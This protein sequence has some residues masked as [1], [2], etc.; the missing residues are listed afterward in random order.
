MAKARLVY[1]E[2]FQS[3][4]LIDLPAV[5]RLL[6]IGLLVHCTDDALIRHSPSMLRALL[7]PG[8]RISVTRLQHFLDTFV[9]RSMLVRCKNGNL[10]AYRITNFS[11]YQHLR[12]RKDA[13][14]DE[15][16][17]ELEGEGEWEFLARTEQR[18]IEVEG[19]G[20]TN[21]AAG[22][23]QVGQENHG[24]PGAGLASPASTVPPPD[25]YIGTT[26][27]SALNGE[28][29]RALPGGGENSPLFDLIRARE[30]LLRV[31]LCATEAH[32]C[33]AG[34]SGLADAAQRHPMTLKDIEAWKALVE[35]LQ[36]KGKLDD[37]RSY[38]R[39]RALRFTSPEAA[40]IGGMSDS[41]KILADLDRFKAE[42]KL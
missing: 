21:L 7:L 27:Q 19:G 33:Q 17:G 39:S 32:A 22:E 28:A 8:C 29:A 40:G 11:K 41:K 12:R 37:P 24:P 38:V 20:K 26:P 4:D 13:T 15:G 10:S 14:E 35:R 18:K 42:G 6:W 36:K 23:M 9:T 3:A 30:E 2:L 34:W 25:G 1:R 16:E 31:Q 5:A